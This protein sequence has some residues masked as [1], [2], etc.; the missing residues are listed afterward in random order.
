MKK[1]GYKPKT[2]MSK[3]NKIGF[4]IM[5]GSLFTM[6]TLTIFFGNDKEVFCVLPTL[7]IGYYLYEF[8]PKQRLEI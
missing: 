1:D 6:L 4:G 8:K 7:I 5:L 2:K 3:V